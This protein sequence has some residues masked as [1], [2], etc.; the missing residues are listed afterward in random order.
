MGCC[1]STATTDQKNELVSDKNT[2][3]PPAIVVDE[4]T[5]VKEVLSETTLL[6]T[7][8]IDNS[9]LE[10]KTTT[11]IQQQDEEKK[12]ETVVNFAPNPVMTKP[13]SLEPEI[14]SLSESLLSIVNGY[15]EE[16]AKQ[17]K[18]HVV[19]QRSPAKSRNR[20]MV[21]YPNRRSDM[22]PGK[23]DPIQR[24]VMMSRVGQS[25]GRV[26]LDPSKNGSGKYCNHY[27]CQGSVENYMFAAPKDS[28]ENPLASLEYFIF[29]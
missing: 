29:L 15:G 14:C 26:R 20:V 18:S 25:P 22:S 21:N 27:H 9:T 4:E 8:S 16:E 5:I 6:T 3:P 13:G 19:R 12:P 7:S 10:K 23:R 2:T 28:F 24:S 17:M 1:L 11:K